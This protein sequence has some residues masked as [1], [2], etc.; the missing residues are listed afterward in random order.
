MEVKVFESMVGDSATSRT[1][2]VA[3]RQSIVFLTQGA[4]HGF[5]NPVTHARFYDADGNLHEI[6]A[7]RLLQIRP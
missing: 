4:A 6:E 3:D 2:T 7:T 1:F 5:V